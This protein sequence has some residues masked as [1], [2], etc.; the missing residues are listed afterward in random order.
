[1]S[2]EMDR[3]DLAERV[4][5]IENMMAEG[6]RQ[7]ESW[8]WTFVLWGLAYYVAYFW[9]SALH[10]IYA[11]PITV[12][13]AG[14]LTFAGF[15]RK[16]SA[17]HTTLGRAIVAVWTASGLSL[18]IL[19]DALGFAGHLTDAHIFLAA[20]SA[21]LGLANV[22][23]GLTLKWKAEIACGLVWWATSVIASFG[24]AQMAEHA[25]LIAVFLGQIVFGIYAMV[26]ESRRRRMSGVAHA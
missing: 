20:F 23:C 12:V 14:L 22:A 5:L 6:R 26:L 15:M 3:N 10:Y 17:S 13:V 2:G 19:F 11:W 8:G 1:M 24:S 9:A 18:F 7:C 25:F 21:I 16:P 4:R